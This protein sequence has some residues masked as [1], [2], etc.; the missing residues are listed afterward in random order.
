MAASQT[1]MSLS[2]T[3]LD[4]VIKLLTP[5]DN[6]INKRVQYAMTQFGLKCIWIGKHEIT[7]SQF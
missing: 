6:Q 2:D 1:I 3:Q 7:N 5:L 4:E